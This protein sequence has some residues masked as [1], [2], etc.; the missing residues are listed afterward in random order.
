[1]LWIQLNV[2]Y[3][4]KTVNQWIIFQF[5]VMS[6][7]H[8]LT[9]P[10][11]IFVLRKLRLLE[12][13]TILGNVQLVFRINILILLKLTQLIYFHVQS[14]SFPTKTKNCLRAR[15]AYVYT[16]LER[17]LMSHQFPF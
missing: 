3:A 5:F 2:P 16:G 14:A 6:V 12:K 7:A 15:E 4:E 1:M 10:V 11:L 13:T 9:A 8:G 17:I